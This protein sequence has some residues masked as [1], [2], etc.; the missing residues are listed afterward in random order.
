FS[1]KA[2]AHEAFARLFHHFRDSKLVVSYS[3]N[4]I[5]NKK[6]MIDL[7][8]QEKKHVEVYETPHRYHSGN[9]A[10]KVGDNNSAVTEYLF[11]AT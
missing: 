7:L 2:G 5:P 9:Q 6:E 3:S 10:N 4:C 8:R 1:K 11:V